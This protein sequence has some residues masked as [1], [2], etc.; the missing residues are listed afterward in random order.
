MLRQLRM[1]VY[2][3][4]WVWDPVHLGGLQYQTGYAKVKDKTEVNLEKMPKDTQNLKEWNE[5]FL[6]K[7]DIPASH[8]LTELKIASLLQQCN[9]VTYGNRFANSC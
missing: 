9:P 4:L 8:Y 3:F 1:S 5:S 6:E 2:V 7:R